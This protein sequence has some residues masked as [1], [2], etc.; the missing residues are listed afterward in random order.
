M[1]YLGGKALIAESLA[2]AI[3]SRVT[4]DSRLLEPFIGGG[5][6][7]EWLAPHFRIARAGDTHESLMM[8]WQAA[9]AG[10]IPPS[11]VTEE[12][13]SEERKRAASAMHAFVGFGCSYAGKW[14][15][16]YARGCGDYALKAARSVTAKGRVLSHVRTELRRCDFAEWDVSNGDVIYCDPP[17]KGTTGYEVG[18]FVSG[19]FWR[20]ASEW[21]SAGAIVFVSEYTAPP[22]WSIVW[23]KPRRKHVGIAGG[24]SGGEAIEKLYVPEGTFEPMA[25]TMSLFT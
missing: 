1:V 17:Y 19:R 5:S 8:L 23:E 10:W 20:K 11:I 4:R 14:W 7:H 9:Q 6:V 25:R 13:Y 12:E 21:T 3:R 16:G 15:G 18:D 22:G 2:R 24:G